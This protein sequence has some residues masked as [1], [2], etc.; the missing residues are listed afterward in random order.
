MGGS[1]PEHAAFVAVQSPLVVA[2]ARK[3]EAEEYFKREQF[4]AAV[5][6][7][8]E[9]EAVASG[10]GDRSPKA[11]KLMVSI[12]LNLALA[13]LKGGDASRAARACDAALA[14]EP[15][16]VKARLAPRLPRSAFFQRSGG[17]ILSAAMR[18]SKTTS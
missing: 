5:A 11:V 13:A 1:T 15:N 18:S 10:S 14:L 2:E 9:A 4:G 17:L 6:A 8:G 12:S 16:N 3:R 7:F